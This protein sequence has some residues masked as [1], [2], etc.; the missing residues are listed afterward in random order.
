MKLKFSGNSDF[1][2]SQKR[3]FW[4][5]RRKIDPSILHSIY[6]HPQNL[7]L[8]R[9]LYLHITNTHKCRDRY[10]FC[11]KCLLL[12]RWKLILALFFL[13]MRSTIHLLLCTDRHH[14]ITT[15]LWF[16]LSHFR[17][18]KTKLFSRSPLQIYRANRKML[19]SGHFLQNS[20]RSL[21]LIDES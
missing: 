21:H 19:H 17:M 5:M 16:F 12:D 13:C 10:E 9:S 2:I 8:Y 11:K 20:Y 1:G 18:S 3:I 15:I 4:Q 7:I 6:Y 14:S